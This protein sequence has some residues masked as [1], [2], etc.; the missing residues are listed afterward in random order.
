MTKNI[1][2]FLAVSTILSVNPLFADTL[3]NLLDKDE[4]DFKEFIENDRAEIRERRERR[5]RYGKTRPNVSKCVLVTASCTSGSGCVVDNLKITNGPG[6]VDNNW[7]G[8]TKNVCPGYNNSY[9][10]TYTYAIKI[11]KKQ[12]LGNF[13]I[14]NNFLSN[15]NIN[16]Y[17]N[18]CKISYTNH[19]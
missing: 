3:S 15:I 10:G 5:E 16:L 2:I 7:S 17:S 19:N 12:C 1:A 13:K 18:N 9:A 14:N 11:G 8:S 4:K 6:I